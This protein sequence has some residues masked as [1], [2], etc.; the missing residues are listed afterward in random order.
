MYPS[1]RSLPLQTYLFCRI[2]LPPASVQPLFQGYILFSYALQQMWNHPGIK[3]WKTR[4]MMDTFHSPLFIYL[5]RNFPFI[6]FPGMLLGPKR[7]LEENVTHNRLPDLFL[8]LKQERSAMVLVQY[9]QQELHSRLQEWSRE[10]SSLFCMVLSSNGK[11]SRL[12]L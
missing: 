4:N 5:E 10:R 9:L 7:R 3:R 8:P 2:C 11:E 1:C 6:T 12:S